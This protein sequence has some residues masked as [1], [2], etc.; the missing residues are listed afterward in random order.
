M[1]GWQ[2]QQKPTIYNSTL[3]CWYI[4]AKHA[5]KFNH[6]LRTYLQYVKDIWIKYE[7]SN[8]YNQQKP[9]SYRQST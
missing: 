1:F 4:N 8:E 7:Q 9:F 2:Q 5:N 3:R 6:K